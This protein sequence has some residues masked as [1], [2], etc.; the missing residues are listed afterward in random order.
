M[1]LQ[2]HRGYSCGF[3]LFT[4]QDC[5][6]RVGRAGGK[7]G[8]GLLV[9][10]FV[11]APSP[12]WRYLAASLPC[13]YMRFVDYSYELAVEQTGKEELE[14]RTIALLQLCVGNSAEAHEG[15]NVFSSAGM[16]YENCWSA[17]KRKLWVWGVVMTSAEVLD[18]FSEVFQWLYRK[19][20]QHR[21]M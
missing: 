6:M 10:A 4:N 3:V 20:K 1:L 14:W 21:N 9:T 15:D 11:N 12:P 5:L 16:H 2:F 18:Y 19:R 17:T 7:E 13:T 8:F